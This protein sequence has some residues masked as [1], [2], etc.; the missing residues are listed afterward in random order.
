MAGL[1]GGAAA[2]SGAAALAAGGLPAGMEAGVDAGGG[3]LPASWSGFGTSGAGVLDS[4]ERTPPPM[5]FA[6]GGEVAA[7]P[8]A[9]A[10]KTLAYMGLLGARMGMQPQPQAQ[11]S[12][13]MGMGSPAP[14]TQLYPQAAA[15]GAGSINPNEIAMI[16]AYLKQQQSN[17]NQWQ[18]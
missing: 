16:M 17:G 4:V 2:D 14:P 12:R 11:V 6:T 13:P 9:R 3:A 15:G 1:M 7:N 8:F 10:G 18:A 5:Q